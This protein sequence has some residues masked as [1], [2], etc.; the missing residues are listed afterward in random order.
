M[1]YPHAARR[2]GMDKIGPTRHD[3]PAAQLQHHVSGP[4][5]SGLGERFSGPV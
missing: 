1:I 2:G 5:P 4:T 3:N